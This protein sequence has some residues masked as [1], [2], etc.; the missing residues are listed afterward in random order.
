MAHRTKE[1]SECAPDGDLS[2][3][4]QDVYDRKRQDAYVRTV[5]AA[6]GAT[7]A[8]PLVMCFGWWSF[9]FPA[10]LLAEAIFRAVSIAISDGWD[11]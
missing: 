6:V 8:V 10:V 11:A 1:P 9:L 7:F 4:R 3:K 2:R 5:G